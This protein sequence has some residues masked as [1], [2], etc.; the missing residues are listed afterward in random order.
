MAI[1]EQVGPALLRRPTAP[2]AAAPLRLR[3]HRRIAPR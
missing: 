2:L 1:G 3:L